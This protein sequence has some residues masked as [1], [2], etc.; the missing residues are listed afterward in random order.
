MVFHL[1]RKFREVKENLR[2]STIS[3]IISNYVSKF[4]SKIVIFIG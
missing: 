1:I 2:F 4:Y 3:I